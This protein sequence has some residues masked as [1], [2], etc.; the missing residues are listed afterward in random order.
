MREWQMAIIKDAQNNKLFW[1]MQKSKKK[2]KKKINDNNTQKKT[3][4]FYELKIVSRRYNN[5]M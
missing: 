4:L 2:K 3:Q 5:Y 1:S